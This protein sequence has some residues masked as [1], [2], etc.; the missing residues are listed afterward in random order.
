MNAWGAIFAAL[1]VIAFALGFIALGMA[2]A[3]RYNRIAWK[4]YYEGKGERG[5][6]KC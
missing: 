3:N 6:V 4:K 5:T 1:A 2:V